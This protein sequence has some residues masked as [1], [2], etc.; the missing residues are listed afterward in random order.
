MNKTS[1]I[2]I[3]AIV[4]AF[5]FAVIPAFAQNPQQPPSQGQGQPG[6]GYPNQNP[7][8]PSPG[9]QPGQGQSQ[10]NPNQQ[11]NHGQGQQQSNMSVTDALNQMGA[12]SFAQ[13]LQQTGADKQLSQGGP[14]TIF[15]PSNQAINSLPQDTI[16]KLKNNQD[17]LKQTLEN[18]IYQGNLTQNDLNNP[19]LKTMNGQKLDI[20][21]KDG[22]ATV[23]GHKV[24]NATEFQNGVIYEIDGVMLPPS[25]QSGGNSGGNQS[26]G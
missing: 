18:H 19:N 16:N 4:A 15:A 22:T 24:L 1:T 5:S 26:N 6:Q 14:Y 17:L 9:Q 20:T 23:N 2:T 7:N 10:Q 13:I 8:Q 3:L 11:P 21:E 12:T 25:V